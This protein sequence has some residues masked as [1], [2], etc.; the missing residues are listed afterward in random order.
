MREADLDPRAREPVE[1]AAAQA[2][3]A[4]GC[5]DLGRVD[6]ILDESRSRRSSR[7]TRSRAY[8]TGPTRY[9]A[10]AAGMDFTELIRRVISRR[11]RESA[12]RSMSRAT[13]SPKNAPATT[14]EGR[15]AEIRRRQGHRDGHGPQRQAG[16]PAAPAPACRRTTWRRAPDGTSART[17][18]ASERQLP[19]SKGRARR[20]AHFT[21]VL[22]TSV[23]STISIART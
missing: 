6:L 13:A 16:S 15:H 23:T 8:G 17:A 3:R 21:A 10:Q 7:S 18:P 5:R 19:S 1:Q 11:P 14:S 2:Y 22:I 20:T 4:A 9:A 12:S